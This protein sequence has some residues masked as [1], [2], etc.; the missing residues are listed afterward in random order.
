MH[1]RPCR[2]RKA[3]KEILG[4]LGLEIPDTL[5]G[6][7]RFDHA[8]WPP[9]KIDSGSRQR[10]VHRHQ[11]ISRAPNAFLIPKRD[12]D[13]LTQ[14]DPYILHGVVLIHIEIAFRH[15]LQIETTV[16]RHE[17]EHVIEKPNAGVNI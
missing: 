2:L 14:R 4:K 10:F 17:I 15:N 13:R 7:S 8:E 16:S 3:L 9:A 11:E 12:G 1:V 5:S 6:K